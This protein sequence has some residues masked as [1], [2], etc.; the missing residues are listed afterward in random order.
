M[1]NTMTPSGILAS[2]VASPRSPAEAT[3]SMLA[4][5][6]V[7]NIRHCPKFS[8]TALPRASTATGPALNR[9][10]W[11]RGANSDRT[12]H[13]TRVALDSH[14][15]L[16]GT[17]AYVRPQVDTCGRISTTVLTGEHRSSDSEHGESSIAAVLPSSV[18]RPVVP[19]VDNHKFSNV[20]E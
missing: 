6:A 19:D 8:R 13:K 18:E 7:A 4:A 2:R 3:N 1:A 14:T 10:R 5:E 11:T 17:I 12:N 20:W 16:T 15:I 9:S